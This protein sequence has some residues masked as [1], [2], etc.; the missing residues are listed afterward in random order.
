MT[1]AA[2]TLVDLGQLLDRDELVTAM[3]YALR[4]RMCTL[5]QIDDILDLLAHKAGTGLVREV[6]V[7]LGP[8]FESFIEVVLGKGF[9][10]GGVLGLTPQ[11]KIYDPDGSLV[12][13]ADFGDEEARLLFEADG[14]AST[15]APGSRHA[16]AAEIGSC[17]CA[18]GRRFATSRTTSCV[19]CPTRFVTLA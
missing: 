10:A 6:S 1:T 16:T 19:I 9:I 12:A 2:R 8:G 14:R 15:G 11:I 4:E 5:D 3:T 13:K 18:G 7:E 17:C